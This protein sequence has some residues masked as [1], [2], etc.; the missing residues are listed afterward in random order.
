MRKG[1]ARQVDEGLHAMA[2]AL[3]VVETTGEGWFEAELHRLK[4][5][6]LLNADCGLPNA[7]RR[8]VSERPLILPAANKPNPRNSAPP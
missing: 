2:E 4:G 8:R 3:E 6:L 5:E 7:H 1:K